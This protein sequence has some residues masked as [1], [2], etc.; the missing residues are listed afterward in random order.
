MVNVL[1]ALIALTCAVWSLAI[2]GFYSA[3]YSNVINWIIFTHFSA[4]F[5]A[6]IFFIFSYHFPKRF[7]KMI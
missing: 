5:I 7:W 1:F 2:I 3:E 4:I 6:F